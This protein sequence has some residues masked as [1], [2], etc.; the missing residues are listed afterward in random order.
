MR[1]GV[2]QPQPCR[3]RLPARPSREQRRDLADLPPSGARVRRLAEACG[4]LV[5]RGGA[6]AKRLCFASTRPGEGRGGGRG[7]G[8][9]RVCEY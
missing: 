6:G 5:E 1:L 3:R 4:A 9:V 8:A 7:G 2:S